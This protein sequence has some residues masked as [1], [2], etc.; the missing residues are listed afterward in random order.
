MSRAAVKGRTSADV[1]A[2]AIADSALR[3]ASGWVEDAREQLLVKFDRIDTLDSIRMAMDSLRS[4]R[5]RIIDS[6][7]KVIR[8]GYLARAAEFDRGRK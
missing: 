8:D 1:E 2:R 3:E 7:P 5:T 4:A 6:L